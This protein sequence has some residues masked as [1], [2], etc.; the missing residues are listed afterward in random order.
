MRLT[1]NV[2]YSIT[3]KLGRRAAPWQEED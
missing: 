2:F 1:G 3:K